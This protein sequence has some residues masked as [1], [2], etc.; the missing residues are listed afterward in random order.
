MLWYETKL[1]SSRLCFEIFSVIHVIDCD[2]SMLARIGEVQMKGKS[3]VAFYIDSTSHN[4]FMVSYRI[5][6]FNLLHNTAEITNTVIQIDRTIVKTDNPHSKITTAS[7][8]HT[9][10]FGSSKNIEVHHIFIYGLILF[11]FAF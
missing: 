3:D 10:L 11:Y 5:V 2:V 6:I 9:I 4:Q 1:L 7:S 8:I